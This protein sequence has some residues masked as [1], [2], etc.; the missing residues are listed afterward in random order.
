MMSQVDSKWTSLQI[1]IKV[2]I[3][4]YLIYVV[5]FYLFRKAVQLY[6]TLT[7]IP[8]TIQAFV[9]T[10]PIVTCI[11]Y[12]TG[13]I[14]LNSYSQRKSLFFCTLVLPF[15][16]ICLYKS[17]LSI[18]YDAKKT[19]DIDDIV[20]ISNIPTN[21]LKVSISTIKSHN[22]EYDISSCYIGLSNSKMNEL[23]NQTK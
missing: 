22:N 13:A 23:L 9:N 18:W 1:V 14:I 20:I 5:S 10:R 11:I 21:R 3:V 16:W 4:L 7:K 19:I 15:A 17:K 6:N 8:E 12:Y 2:V